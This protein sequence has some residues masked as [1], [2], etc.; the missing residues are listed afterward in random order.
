M[1]QS[2]GFFDALE[3]NG[4]YDRTYS[5]ADYCD[6]LAAVIKTGVVKD[7]VNTNNDLAVSANNDMSVA[8]APGRAWINGH[9]YYNDTELELDIATAPVT[10]SRIDRVVLRLDTSTATRSIVAAVKT[11]SAAAT[12]TPPEL[13]REGDIYEICLANIIV[14]NGISAMTSGEIID[15]RNDNNVCGWAASVS[16][17]VLTLLQQFVWNETLTAAAQTVAFNIP[18]YRT[19]VAQII[20]V[21]TNGVLEVAGVDYTLNENIITFTNEKAAGTEITVVLQKSVDTE[22]IESVV[23]QITELQNQVA[24]LES[25]NEY[26]YKCNGIDDNVKLGAFVAQKVVHGRSN[27]TVKVRVIGGNFGI[28]NAFIGAGTAANP[29]KFFVFGVEHF[30]SNRII[31]DFANAG[32]INVPIS[33]GTYNYIFSAQ[34]G[35]CI[36]KNADIVANQTGANTS[37]IMFDPNSPKPLLVKD[38]RFWI[39]ASIES[40]IAENG[41]FENCRGSVTTGAAN[42]YCFKGSAN[43]LLRVQGGEYYA[44]NSGSNTNAVIFN[45]QSNAVIILYGVNCPTVSRSGYQQINAILSTAGK[46]SITDTITTLTVSATGANIRGTLAINKNGLM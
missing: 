27:K 17:A 5:A 30:E 12:P 41:T 18:Q 40:Y 14:N 26:I 38:S 16:P 8:V 7:S 1:A 15:T 37:I 19:D 44:Y 31:I 43:G 23:G 24:V 25:D 4:V 46:V 39:N 28:T 10:N 35:A 20:N 42:V 6:N 21:Y 2:S 9:Y 3:N 11:G 29:Y 36:I 32:S 34:Y 22:N 33:A 45:S 13:T